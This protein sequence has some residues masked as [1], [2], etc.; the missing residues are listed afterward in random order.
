VRTVERVDAFAERL[1]E[2]PL[3]LSGMVTGTEKLKV[4]SDG[5]DACVIYDLKTAPVPNARTF[6]WYRL[7]DGKIAS[8][9][10]MFDA[11]PFAPLFEGQQGG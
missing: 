6:E 11:R 1:H 3:Q 7:R 2:V 8:I 4:F 10:A 5:D 9:S